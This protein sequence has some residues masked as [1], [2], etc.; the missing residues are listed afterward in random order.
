MKRRKLNP[1]RI[2]F[3]AQDCDLERRKADA[4]SE[5]VLQEWAVILAALSD[6]EGVTAESMQALWRKVERAETKLLSFDD[7]RRELK[8]IRDLAGISMPLCET[9]TEIRTQGDFKRYVQK[10]RRN[11][12]SGAFALIIEPMIR[13]SMLPEDDIYTIVKKAVAMNEEIADGMI[14]VWDIQEMLLEEYGVQLEGI[15]EATALKILK[16]QAVPGIYEDVGD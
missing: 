8:A 2:P 7:V 9:S 4:I 5:M 10:T 14:T 3:Q 11:S 15:G 13:E 1:N 12:C 16:E 6:F